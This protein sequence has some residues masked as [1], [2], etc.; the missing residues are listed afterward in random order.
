M[1]CEYSSHFV[2]L[3]CCKL[4]SRSIDVLDCVGEVFN[5]PVLYCGTISVIWEC[6]KYGNGKQ[7]YINL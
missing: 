7:H 6:M 2:D 4:Y 5:E 1:V 3:I